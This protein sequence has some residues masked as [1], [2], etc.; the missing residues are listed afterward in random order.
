MYGDGAGIG[1]A[2]MRNR[3][4]KILRKFVDCMGLSVEELKDKCGLD[5][6]DIS[7]IKKEL[8]L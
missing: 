2:V 3:Y 6:K 5:D 4:K 7:F 1:Y 8:G